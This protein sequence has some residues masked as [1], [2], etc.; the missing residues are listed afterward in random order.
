MS[1][2]CHC[3]HNVQKR[4]CQHGD[5]CATIETLNNRITRLELQLQV[6]DSDGWTN[7]QT[8]EELKEVSG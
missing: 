8:D 3:I 4:R 1:Q 5:F 2:R 6:A 7:S